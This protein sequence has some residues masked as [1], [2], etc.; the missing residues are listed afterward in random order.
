MDEDYN[1][2]H[3]N[4]HPDEDNPSSPSTYHS[5]DYSEKFDDSN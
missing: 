5:S 1:Y 4:E 2:W 3:G